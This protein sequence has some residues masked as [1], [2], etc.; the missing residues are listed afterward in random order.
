MPI[1]F[2][3]A[4]LSNMAA[5]SLKYS[6]EKLRP[7]IIFQPT[8][9]PYS[10]EIGIQPK[11]HCKPGGLPGQLIPLLSFHTLVIGPPDSAASSAAPE[12]SKS[13]WNALNCLCKAGVFICIC[14]I[15]VRSY[16]TGRFLV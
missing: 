4:S 14:T 3:A 9:L 5:E 10:G 15:P 16:P 1:N 11:S 7:D 13:L 2:T 6:G 8:V 12:R